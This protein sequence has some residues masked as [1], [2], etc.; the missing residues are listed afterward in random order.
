MK[1][2]IQRSD[3]R[4]IQ[5]RRGLRDFWYKHCIWSKDIFMEFMGSFISSVHKLV[6]PNRKCFGV[7]LV[8]T[9]PLLLLLRTFP[10]FC[11]YVSKYQDLWVDLYLSGSSA[12]AH[13][14]HSLQIQSAVS[15]YRG[16]CG[17]TWC[18]S[19]TYLN[20]YFSY[21]FWQSV[22]LLIHVMAVLLRDFELKFSMMCPS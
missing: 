3:E 20:D 16:H 11:I 17:R 18:Q 5:L 19:H 14:F 7:L 6:F 2:L 13:Y 4:H 12:A 15:K 9:F 22:S 8:R 21:T 10:F 1:L